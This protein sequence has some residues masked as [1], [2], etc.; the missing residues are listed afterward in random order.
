[1]PTLNQRLKLRYIVA[2]Y[3]ARNAVFATA[4]KNDVSL[5][6]A[7]MLAFSSGIF[8]AISKYKVTRITMEMRH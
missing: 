1:M 5:L 3:P 4:P 6:E 8:V 2:V 7:S